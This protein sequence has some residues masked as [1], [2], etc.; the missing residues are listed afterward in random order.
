MN[1]FDLYTGRH[2]EPCWAG[3]SRMAARALREHHLGR[4]VIVDHAGTTAMLGAYRKGL[5]R[6]RITLL[7]PSGVRTVV[8]PNR[9]IVV[10]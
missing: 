4:M 5:L 3:P 6:T 7:L 9:S 2:V 10:A 1:A 8:V